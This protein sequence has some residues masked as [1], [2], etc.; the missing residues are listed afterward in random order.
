MIDAINSYSSNH[1]GRKQNPIA[2]KTFGRMFEDRADY[3]VSQNKTEQ[4][5]KQSELGS[6]LFVSG[7]SGAIVLITE[8]IVNADQLLKSNFSCVKDILKYSGLFALIGASRFGMFK[9]IE[10]VAVDPQDR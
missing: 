9:L 2:Q 3:F 6:F 4:K 5:P 7:C 8:T 10:R 1:A